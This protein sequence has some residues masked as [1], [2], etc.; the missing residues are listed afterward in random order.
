MNNLVKCPKCATE[1]LAEFSFCK[2]C[3]YYLKDIGGTAAPIDFG[4]DITLREI[5]LVTKDPSG[6]YERAF[7]EMHR[8][9][10]KININLPVLLSGLFF[11]MPFIW[12]F[13]RKMYKIGTVILLFTLALSFATFYCGV[14][15]TL[16]FMAN[17]QTAVAATSDINFWQKLT[18]ASNFIYDAFAVGISLFANYFYKNYCFKKIKS[19]K[20]NTDL[21]LA[22]KPTSIAAAAISFIV[23]F[24]ALIFCIFFMC[25]FFQP[26]LS[27]YLNSSEV[28]S[29]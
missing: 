4:D 10:K 28:I 3:G 15:Y 29:L 22:Q 2:N 1:N 11:G 16:L 20:N 23:W 5:A 6:K 13:Y 9:G 7:C 18:N 21:L 8:T 12:F 24:L 26:N 17:Y 19:A 27:Y 25:F 14:N